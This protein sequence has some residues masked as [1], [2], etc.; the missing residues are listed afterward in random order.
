MDRYAFKSDGSGYRGAQREHL[1]LF[2]LQT[3]VLEQLTSGPFDDESPAWSPDGRWIA[4][5][6]N[7]TADPDRNRNT[8]VFVVEARAGAT[9]RRLTTYDGR[10]DGSLAWSPDGALIAYR[11]G[12]EARHSAYNFYRLA[13]VPVAGGAPRVLAGSLDRSMSAPVWSENGA[14]VV[15]I[16]TDDRS[17]YLARVPLDGGAVERLSLIHI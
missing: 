5:V 11:Q 17:R 3:R 13:V 12:S 4:F 2:D 9:P 16:V 7:R 14:G 15:V 10:D 8:D 1:Y 6:S